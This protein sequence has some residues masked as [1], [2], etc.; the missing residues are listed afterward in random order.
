ME[1]LN[2]V[3]SVSAVFKATALAFTSEIPPL[4]R[5]QICPPDTH[6]LRS[7]HACLEVQTRMSGGPDT[8][9]WRSRHACLEVKT[10][11]FMSWLTDWAL[12]ACVERLGLAFEFGV[13]FPVGGSVPD[14]FILKDRISLRIQAV[15]GFKGRPP[16]SFLHR[17][18]AFSFTLFL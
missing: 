14:I 5:S 10:R 8:H 16:S 15:A 2:L 7:R 3:P 18:H 1:E 17:S 9:V 12:F 4:K 13:K 11:V 6:V